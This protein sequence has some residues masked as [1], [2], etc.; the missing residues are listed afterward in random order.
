MDYEEFDENPEE[1]FINA[2]KDVYD[3]CLTNQKNH[4]TPASEFMKVL[5]QEV[6]ALKMT[7]NVD[8]QMVLETM[9]PLILKTIYDEKPKTNVEL[10]KAT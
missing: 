10:S 5:I 1:E 8:N 4:E 2:A 6:K 3:T 9:V 7:Y